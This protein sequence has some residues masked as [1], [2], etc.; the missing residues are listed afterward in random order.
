M[1]RGVCCPG[2]FTVARSSPGFW[3]H[4]SSAMQFFHIPNLIDTE[5]CLGQGATTAIWFCML[6]MFQKQKQNAQ[7][8]TLICASGIPFFFVFRND[9]CPCAFLFLQAL[10]IVT[11]CCCMLA[12]DSLLLG[13]AVALATTSAWLYVWAVSMILLW[14]WSLPSFSPFVCAS[15]GAVP[16]LSSSAS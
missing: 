14:S 7:L 15:C 12:S 8:G 11:V 10:F 3:H 6:R 1:L 5:A 2:Y 9:A 16:V 4:G 13:P